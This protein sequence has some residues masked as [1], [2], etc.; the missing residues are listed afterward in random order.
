MADLRK[1][2]PPHVAK[3]MLNGQSCDKVRGAIGL[4]GKCL[5][6]PIPVNGLVRVFKFLGK[7]RVDNEEA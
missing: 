3:M 1:M 6:N 7:L 4:F 2:Y 5:P